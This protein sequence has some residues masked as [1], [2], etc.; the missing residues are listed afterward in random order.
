[1]LKNVSIKPVHSVKSAFGGQVCVS[2]N[3]LTGLN[4]R[5]TKE[6]EAS[7]LVMAAGFCS[8]RSDDEFFESKKSCAKNLF[9]NGRSI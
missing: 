8:I 5:I 3:Y 1:M 2:G 7:F 9:N 6:L 4:E